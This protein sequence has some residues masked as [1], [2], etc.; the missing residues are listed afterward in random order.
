MT[1][2]AAPARLFARR[3]AVLATAA[4]VLASALVAGAALLLLGGG[5]KAGIRTVAAATGAFELSYPAGWEAA[6]PPELLATEGRPD[7]LLRRSDS[8]GAVTVHEQPRLD[9][10]LAE[11]KR[12]LDSRLERRM[13]DAKP[14][15]SRVVALET[16]R[17][18]SYTFVRER[19]GLVHGIVVAPLGGRT[20][21]VET[22]ARGDAA[23]VATQ[24]GGIV[25]SLR[26]GS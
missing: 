4:A 2:I 19:A 3:P 18:L 12:D 11:V 26:P 20:L 10:S 6:G 13:P 15:A 1:A 17:A 22:A 14:V 7:A 16:G 21:M 9:G 24:I 23:D 25:R 5:E 8:R